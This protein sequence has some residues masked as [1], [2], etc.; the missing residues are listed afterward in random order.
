M[1]RLSKI[2]EELELIAPSEGKCP[3]DNVGLLEGDESQRVSRV[4]VC[5]DITSENAAAAAE[6]GADL[7]ISH[8]PL[9]FEPL[10]NITE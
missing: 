3:W 10:K 9:I 5:L 4:F 6:F 1:V 2:I 7:I 8:H